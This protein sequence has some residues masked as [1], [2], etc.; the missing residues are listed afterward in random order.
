MRRRAP[1]ATGLVLPAA[2]ASVAAAGPAWTTP[3]VV[4]P[5]GED[6]A[7]P[8][9]G[10]ASGGATT[11]VWMGTD[12]LASSD[13]RIHLATRGAAGSWTVAP[14]ALSA[15]G[16]FA[17]A[18]AV[19]AD[20]TAVAAWYF[21]VGSV[22]KIQTCVRPAGGAF[23]APVDLTSGSDQVGGVVSVALDAAGSGGIAYPIFGSTKRI[24][25]WL[26]NAGALA[27]A[28]SV[29]P[30][31]T[32]IYPVPTSV[33]PSIV[34]SAGGLA[35]A[36]DKYSAPT[37]LGPKLLGPSV[38]GA[39]VAPADL[40]P[41][42]LA[43]LSDPVIGPAPGG[44]IAAAWRTSTGIQVRVGAE[45]PQVLTDAATGLTLGSA[46]DGTLVAVW[47]TDR[48]FAAVRPASGV[49]FGAPVQL[50][51]PGARFSGGPRLAFAG[52][53]AIVV[54]SRSTD[55]FDRVEV[56]ERPAGGSFSGIADTL[57]GRIGAG[58][59]GDARDPAIA[60]DAQ[61]HAT[62]AWTQTFKDAAT[63]TLYA[64][65]VSTS[66]GQGPADL[67][68]PKVA[69]LK[70][71]SERFA[72]GA[73]LF[74]VVVPKGG[75]STLFPEG[76]MPKPLRAGTQFVF[77]SSEGGTYRIDITGVGCS[78]F[79]KVGRKTREDRGTDGCAALDD[80]VTLTGPATKKVNRVTFFGAGL[81]PGGYYQAE[82]TVTDEAGNVSKSRTVTFYFDAP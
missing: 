28:K 25:V 18:L 67:K 32:S 29:V 20:G 66:L 63:G 60:A 51:E 75:T 64:R 41:A 38:N 40:S 72:A 2:L 55:L 37:I 27:A 69:K 17:P 21:H 23:G 71:S 16:A 11:L 57:S 9:I 50:S 81:T 79:H 78:T 74:D 13:Y 31:G 36:F 47:R 8:E 62:I 53:R 77:T 35:V 10:A 1:W 19:S 73:N 44:Q 34:A 65:V 3:V 24:D 14:D 76:A 45:T 22:Q 49:S 26:V 58:A 82:L 12:S 48:V 52:N 30:G 4:S 33:R 6:A 7:F 42:P 5:A 15:G 61:G 54:W 43:S 56:S 59:D 39:F 46:P 68:A 70:T 80:A